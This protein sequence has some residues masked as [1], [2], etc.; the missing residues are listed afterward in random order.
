MALE[1]IWNGSG[2]ALEWL[3]N[4]SGMAMERIGKGSGM[5]LELICVDISFQR[6]NVAYCMEGRIEMV[7]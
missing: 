6:G 5:F 7:S 3:W 4:D 1:W 2:M